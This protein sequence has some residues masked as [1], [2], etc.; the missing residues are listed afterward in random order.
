MHGGAAILANFFAHYFVDRSQCGRILHSLG[1]HFV[2]LQE[3]RQ[4]TAFE[5]HEQ[6]SQ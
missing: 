3:M 1:F 5:Q 4:E 2:M 6:A